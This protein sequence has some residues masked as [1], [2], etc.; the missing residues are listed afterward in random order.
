M[1]YKEQS[2]EGTRAAEVIPVIRTVAL[3]GKGTED[4]PNAF[5][6]KYWS[7]EGELLATRVPGREPD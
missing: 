6:Y 5:E 4:G 7:I 2:N 3:V 1:N